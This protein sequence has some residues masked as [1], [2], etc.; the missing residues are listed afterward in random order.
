MAAL[1]E[2]PFGR[3]YGSVDSTPLF[4]ILAGAYYQRTGDLGFVQE[5]WPNIE[6]ALRWIDVY[7]DL[8][9]DGFVE[10]QR[11]SST[12][13]VQQGWKDS[14]D[15]VF[16]ADGTLAE[17]PIALCE[18]QAYVF[19]AKGHAAEM[20][21]A[22]RK[23]ERSYELERQA[24]SLRRNF[25]EAFWRPDLATYALA[26]DGDKRPCCVR[27]SNAGHCLFGGIASSERAALV[28]RT[29]LEEDSF[30]GWGVRTLSSREIRYNAMSYHNGSVWPHDNAL[31][32]SGLARY[33]H[34]EGAAKILTGLFDASIFLD[35]HRLPE[36]FCGFQRRSGEGPTQYPVACSPQSWAAASVFLL[37]EA[38]LGLEIQTSPPRVLF[39]RAELPE[40]LPSIQIFNL[41]VGDATVDLALERGERSVGVT[42][43][44][45]PSYIDIISIK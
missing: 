23:R 38:C 41:P 39:R 11:R 32:A 33:G 44:Q 19:A 29:L 45:K 4:I 34:K 25:E 28:G 1:K 6:A 10:Y 27:S 24:E 26:L 12:G 43:L 40:S 42:V 2:I 5:I 21:L 9:R 8:D 13:L 15:S 30:S 17:A 36:L 18:V 31:I 14:N 3:Y 20:A 37:L 7:G 35:L 22:L 16:H